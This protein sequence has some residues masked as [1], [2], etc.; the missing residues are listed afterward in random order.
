MRTLRAGA[1]LLAISACLC[2]AASGQVNHTTNVT[3][4][5]V[6]MNG[7]PVPYGRLCAVA[8]D[9]YGNPISFSSIGWGVVSAG[10]PFCANVVNG[11]VAGGLPV[12]DANQTNRATPITYTFSLRLTNSSFVG[13]SAAVV[14]FASVPGVSGATFSLDSYTPAASAVAP[15][16]SNLIGTSSSLPP[17]CTSPSIW[18]VPG[19][20]A[21]PTIYV[22]DNGV[23]AVGA[24]ATPSLIFGTSA[25]TV[26]QGNDARIL[27]SLKNQ[28]AFSTTQSYNANDVVSVGSALY[29]AP[30][31]IAAST[32]APPA[33]GW[34]PLVGPI[35][36][37]GVS[38]TVGGSCSLPLASAAAPGKVQLAPGQTSA[39]LGSASAMNATAFDAAGAAA[40]AQTAAEAASDPAGSAASALA[41]ATAAALLKANN[42]GDVASPA[43]ARTNLGLGSAAT[44]SSSAY[45]A[46]GAAAAAQAAAIAAA[47]AASLQRAAN[48]SDLGN[49]ATARTNLGLGS[50]ATTS[51][52]AYD[53]AGA[54]AAA[55][56]AAIAAAEAASLQ[57]ASNLSDLGNPSVAR[58][59]LGLGSAATTSSSAY[60]AAGAAAAAQAAAE[61]ASDPAGAATAA[62]AAAEA[63]SLQRASN[64]S[65]LASA[66][67]ARTNLGLGSAATTSASAYDAAG[68]AAAAQAAAIAAAEAASVPAAAVVNTQTASYARTCS[69]RNVNMDLSAS[70]TLSV[71]APCGPGD[72]LNIIS[73]GGV[74]NVAQVALASGTWNNGPIPASFTGTLTPAS[75]C[76]LTVA[77][78]TG[79]M[80]LGTAQTISG[81]S[82]T[83]SVPLYESVSAQCSGTP[84]GNGVYTAR[85]PAPTSTIGPMAMTGSGSQPTLA[86]DQWTQIVSPD[87]TNWV[88]ADAGVYGIAPFSQGTLAFAASS[89]Y[90]LSGAPNLVYNYTPPTGLSTNTPGANYTFAVPVVSSLIPQGDNYNSYF[91]NQDVVSSFIASNGCSLANQAANIGGTP[92]VDVRGICFSVPQSSIEYGNN[93]MLIALDSW[94]NQGG[95]PDDVDLQ[96]IAT[97]EVSGSITFNRNEV[98]TEHSIIAASFPIGAV[99]VSTVTGPP[100]VT[101]MTVTSVNAQ[102]V[103][104]ACSAVPGAL[105]N[106]QTLGNVLTVNG[107]PTSGTVQVGQALNVPG[108]YG[109]PYGT[110]ITAQLTTNTFTI[111]CQN[112]SVCPSVVAQSMTAVPTLYVPP[113]VSGVSG[114]ASYYQV[115]VGDTLTDGN[116][117]TNWS[118]WPTITRQ[119]VASPANSQQG[120]GYYQLSAGPNSA[121]AAET[122]TTYGTVVTN[123]PIADQYNSAATFSA[124]L[125]TASTCNLTITGTIGGS[126]IVNYTG[127]SYLTGTGLTA[128][129]SYITGFCP[130]TGTAGQAGVYTVS[131]PVAI[132][133]AETIT[134]SATVP[135]EFPNG[136]YVTAVTTSGGY[137]PLVT[138]TFTLSKPITLAANVFV[139]RVYGL[140]VIKVGCECDITDYGPAREYGLGYIAPNSLNGYYPQATNSGWVLRSILQNAFFS[141]DFGTTAIEFDGLTANLG[142]GGPNWFHQ[143]IVF[144]AALG[145]NAEGI[146]ITA[147]MTATAATGNLNSAVID[148]AGSYNSASGAGIISNYR[149]QV[150]IPSGAPPAYDAWL[151]DNTSYPTAAIEHDLA[152]RFD[153]NVAL[154]WVE[155][156]GAYRQRLIPGTQA[157]NVVT[158]LP[159]VTSELAGYPSAPVVNYVPVISNALNYTFANSSISDNGTTVATTEGFSAASLIVTG[160]GTSSSLVCPNGT[161]GALTTVGCASATSGFPITIGSTSIAAGSTTTSV[162]GLTLT[163]ATFSG[164]TLSGNINPPTV[165]L[166]SLDTTNGFL[167]SS[168][169]PI[170]WTS[171]GY[172]AAV[173]AIESRIAPGLIGARSSSSTSFTVAG[174]TGGF[175]AANFQS[176]GTTFSASGCSASS[177]VGGGSAGSLTLGANSCTLTITMTGPTPSHG[178]NCS[179]NDET[180]KAA[181]ANINQ[182]SHT[183]TSCTVSIPATAAASDVL[184][185]GAF[186]F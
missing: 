36:I 65:D 70:G 87:G 79:Q 111:A 41:A 183:T 6:L 156:N 37:D 123:A 33:N 96:L 106:G 167:T 26:T 2:A 154:A 74:G 55:Q 160:L 164:G 76:N 99:S 59:N 127:S 44:T 13:Q 7:A 63:A 143:G 82:G 42:L 72:T 34:L 62:I 116:G 159:P 173:D 139:A 24:T 17:T 102:A 12:P 142:D 27:A 20:G 126:G 86:P 125:T 150:Y 67:A 95:H 101:T 166:G 53:A 66:S 105:F 69:D 94:N 48:L 158:T 151:F 60:D 77:G 130:G 84:L 140:G 46:S 23:Y 89:G 145:P 9:T 141:G 90:R 49:A 155:A 58:T 112:V 149:Q 91:Y 18:I 177:P 1:A 5:Q 97:A 184:T 78:L 132:A 124:T 85:Y 107:T 32:V 56:T 83:T 10:N 50:A 108:T 174:S 128:S 120:S 161:G 175:V 52:S 93:G 146:E 110:V 29:Y 119:L 51:S 168:T 178:W 147:P 54:A 100:A 136:S 21:T 169:G 148:I 165:F 38:C 73:T 22:C 3:L 129:T 135:Q 133:T 4:G 115:R 98:L 88:G 47:E 181:T 171:G 11:A 80:F 109:L 64:L 186:A 122:M 137:N 40:A 182:I 152:M 172:N 35:T 14:L 121:V 57:R 39:T 61:A 144:N 71:P 153:H 25:G 92:Q 45:D 162:A 15:P 118:T 43:A 68:A 117:T 179:F 180:T 163:G 81:T 138:N 113:S 114:L 8:G 131:N 103:C 176:G 16:A 19:S 170:Y 31:A 28:G 185:F 75:T 134:A 157:A 30:A 104:L